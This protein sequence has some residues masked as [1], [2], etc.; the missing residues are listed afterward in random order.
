M[1]LQP[2]HPDITLDVTTAMSPDQLAKF[3]TQKGIVPL[4]QHAS[5]QH[6]GRSIYCPK[7]ETAADIDLEKIL[8]R[9]Y[10][11]LLGNTAL[12]NQLTKVRLRLLDWVAQRGIEVAGIHLKHTGKDE[13]AIHPEDE[14]PKEQP[15]IKVFMPPRI[16]GPNVTLHNPFG[17]GRLEVTTTQAISGDLIHDAK[18]LPRQ[19]ALAE[20]TGQRLPAKTPIIKAPG[21][22]LLVTAPVHTRSLGVGHHKKPKPEFDTLD[23]SQMRYHTAMSVPHS[24]SPTAMFVRRLREETQEEQT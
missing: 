2:E 24:S 22:N 3:V 15:T 1:S 23:A 8:E 10:S 12:A 14:D 6:L 9:Y 17:T 4:L 21:E 18:K 19:R 5:A 7:F 20:D 16:P 11:I 13:Q